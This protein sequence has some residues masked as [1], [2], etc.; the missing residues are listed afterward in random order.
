MRVLAYPR[1]PGRKGRITSEKTGRKLVPCVQAFLTACLCVGGAG[2]SLPLRRFFHQNQRD[3]KHADIQRTLNA[4]LDDRGTRSP[5]AEPQAARSRT[6][7]V[8]LADALLVVSD[9]TRCPL[10]QST[11]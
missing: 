4:H 10:S 1:L 9:T 3:Q 2:G 5:A 6:G 11:H 8:A 7:A